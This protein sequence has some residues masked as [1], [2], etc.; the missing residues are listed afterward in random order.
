MERK[1]SDIIEQNKY[2]E[3]LGNKIIKKIKNKIKNNWLYFVIDESKDLYSRSI[4]NILVGVL[5]GK[6]SV[7]YLYYT[8]ELKDAPNNKNIF[9]EFLQSLK[10]IITTDDYDK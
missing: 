6:P 5:N 7:P 2:L 4:I 9:T 10:L 8:N 3:I 1:L